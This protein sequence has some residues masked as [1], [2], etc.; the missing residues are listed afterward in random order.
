MQPLACSTCV[1]GI[2]NAA[3]IELSY[4]LTAA[5]QDPLSDPYP[6]DLCESAFRHRPISSQL[7][8]IPQ[9]A[10]LPL[11]TLCRS[12]EYRNIHDHRGGDEP[13]W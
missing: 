4:E 2:T 6:S 10:S 8:P 9:Y 13:I 3:G 7:L 5:C 11:L 12:E 1:S